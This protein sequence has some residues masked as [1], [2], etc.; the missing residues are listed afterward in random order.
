MIPKGHIVS[1]EYEVS[2]PNEKGEKEVI[3][4]SLG[5]EPLKFLLGK[6]QVIEGLEEVV[7]QMEVGDKKE[8]VIPPQKAYGEYHS[9]YLQEVPRD[10][11][12]GIDLSVGQTLFGQGE[13]GQT[14]QVVV[15]DFNNENVI[16]DY[17]HPLAGKELHFVVTVLEAREPTEEDMKVGCCGGEEHHHHG[18]QGGCC[19]GGGCG[20]H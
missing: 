20:C 11:F 12:S 9:S 14:V 7:E 16:V 2:T 3:D 18:H 10:Q 13:D 15:K 4:S 19:G 17:N 1:I 6:G 5:K 8:I